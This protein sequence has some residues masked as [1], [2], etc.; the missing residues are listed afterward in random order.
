MT[1]KEIAN[2]DKTLAKHQA[3]VAKTRDDLDEAIGEMVELREHCKEAWDDLQR[4][5]DALSRFV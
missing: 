5:R 1:K 4:A 2:V 3:K